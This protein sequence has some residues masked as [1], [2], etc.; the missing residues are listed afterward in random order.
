MA[1]EQ[2]SGQAWLLALDECA[3]MG[4]G[5][6]ALRLLAALVS[7]SGLLSL[8]VIGRAMS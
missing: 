6:I 1:D 5:S 7:S 4:N 3:L 8:V 2:T